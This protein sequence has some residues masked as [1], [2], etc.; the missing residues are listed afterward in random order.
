ML[1]FNVFVFCLLC[2]SS[3]FLLGVCMCICFQK[4]AVERDGVRDG[5]DVEKRG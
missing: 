3:F 2:F 5:M 1:L 4:L